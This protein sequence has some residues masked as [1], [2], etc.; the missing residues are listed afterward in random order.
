MS[1]KQGKTRSRLWYIL[2]ALTS[3]IG[4]VIAYFILREDDPGKAKNCLWLG[5]ILT[6]SY[7][8]YYFLFSLMIEIFEF[9]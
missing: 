7:F 3:I 1:E 4:G 6:V 8:A 5:I 2:P 9:T